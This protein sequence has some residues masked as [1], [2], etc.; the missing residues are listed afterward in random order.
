MCKAAQIFIKGLVHPWTR[1][2]LV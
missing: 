2:G 1:L